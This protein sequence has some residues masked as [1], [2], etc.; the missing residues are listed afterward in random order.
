MK[1]AERGL[2]GG[3]VPVR[4]KNLP[5]AV[6]LKDIHVIMVLGWEL[7]PVQIC[8]HG[9]EE[10]Q[11]SS[12]SPKDFRLK[13]ITSSHEGID[14]TIVKSVVFV[15]QW[16]LASVCHSATQ[17]RLLQIRV[18]HFFLIHQTI[19]CISDCLQSH[20]AD[21]EERL[22]LHPIK[23]ISQLSNLFSLFFSVFLQLVVQLYLKWSIFIQWKLHLTTQII[24]ERERNIMASR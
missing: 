23:L 24:E 4:R 8:L 9:A 19:V 5:K 16:Y 18:L 21:K 20:L 17:T 22:L 12:I 10:G 6:C 3:E 11:R 7:R 13:S 2:G 15:H 14:Y 1:P